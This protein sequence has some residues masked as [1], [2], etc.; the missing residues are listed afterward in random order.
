M[1][2]VKMARSG[3][4]G[5]ILIRSTK[6]KIKQKHEKAKEAIILDKKFLWK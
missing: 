3:G 4:T 5:E 1:R 2:E 6:K